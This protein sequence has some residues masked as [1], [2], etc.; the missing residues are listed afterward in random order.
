MVV[1]SKRSIRGHLVQIGPGAEEIN[2]NPELITTTSDHF[3]I[4]S[5]AEFDGMTLRSNR[6]CPA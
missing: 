4:V 2:I 3:R 1:I 6:Y 5:N